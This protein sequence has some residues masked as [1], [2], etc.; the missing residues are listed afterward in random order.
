MLT[1]TG[2]VAPSSQSSQEHILVLLH[3]ISY[4]LNPVKHSLQIVLVRLLYFRESAVIPFDML[5]A[6]VA[7]SEKHGPDGAVNL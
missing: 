7:N 2:G 6:D 1:T 3:L 5:S 4:S